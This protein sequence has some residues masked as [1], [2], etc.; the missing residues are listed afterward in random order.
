MSQGSHVLLMSQTFHNLKC[1]IVSSFP[2]TLIIF[3][4]SGV[5]G[6]S[7]VPGISSFLVV[8]SVS[9]VLS[10]SGFSSGVS[11]QGVSSVPRV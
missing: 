3:G 9:R 10:I 2:G 8:S 1:P 4:V 6:V 11:V 5:P 7:S